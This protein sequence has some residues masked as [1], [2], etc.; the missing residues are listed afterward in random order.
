MKLHADRHD[1]LNAITAYGEGW[2]EVSGIRHEGALLIR[3]EGPVLPWDVAGFEALTPDILLAL[4]GPT[5]L[6]AAAGT[7]PA[8]TAAGTAAPPVQAA[9]PPMRTGATPLQTDTTPETVLPPQA[10]HD[11][12][13]G[14][15]ANATSGDAPTFPRPE[16]ILLGTG[17]RLQFPHPRL[18]RPLQQAG[19]GL[20]AMDTVAACRTYNIL[21][22]EG[23]Q[24]LAALLPTG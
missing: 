22:A 16:V 21:M 20:E 17:N 2:V 24:V 7:V 12:P 14:L 9:P 10:G 1:D 15:P 11:H 4:G 5:V 13:G 8:G 6:A 19:I 3:P 18:T 23:R